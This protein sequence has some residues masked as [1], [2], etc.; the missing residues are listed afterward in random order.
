[1]EEL[2][3]RGYEAIAVATPAGNDEAGLPEYTDAVITALGNRN[4]TNIDPRGPIIGRVSQ[5]RWSAN[6]CFSAPWSLSTPC[7][8]KLR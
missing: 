7:V 8:N 3:A 1:M 6:G 5:R 4:P 2:K